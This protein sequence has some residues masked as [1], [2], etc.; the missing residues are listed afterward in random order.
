METINFCNTNPVEKYHKKFGK[1]PGT[2]NSFELFD[3]NDFS[4]KLNVKNDSWHAYS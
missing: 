4:G 2:R 3:K 1:Y